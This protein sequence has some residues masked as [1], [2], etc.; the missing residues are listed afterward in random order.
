VISL[1]HTLFTKSLSL[2]KY[3]FVFPSL[4]T[5]WAFFCHWDWCK[6]HNTKYPSSKLITKFNQR[7]PF[8]KYHYYIISLLL[9]CFL[10]LLR[11]SWVDESLHITKIGDVNLTCI[12]SSALTV[13]CGASESV[14]HGRS[15]SPRWE[16]QDLCDAQCFL[17]MFVHACVSMCVCL[18][19]KE[20]DT[21]I[22]LAFLLSMTWV[23]E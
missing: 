2:Q 5:A 20:S 8:P 6:S 10:I 19:G 3:F 11:N 13:D 18:H 1:C 17:C 7:Q 9:L 12:R 21:D 14:T 15:V 4:Y 16:G 23:R 22:N